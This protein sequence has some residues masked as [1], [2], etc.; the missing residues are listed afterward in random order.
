MTLEITGP[1]WIF[2]AAND[3]NGDVKF[4]YDIIDDGTTNG[5]DDFLTDNAEISLVVTSERRASGTGYWLGHHAW[6]E[7]SWSSK[8]KTW[9][10]QPLIRK[11]T[12]YRERFGAPIKVRAN[13]NALRTWAALMMRRSL[14]HTWVFTAA[15]EYDGDVK[16]IYTVEDGNNQWRWWFLNRYRRN[17]CCGNWSEWW[18]ASG[19]GY[20]LR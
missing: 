2:T 6:R 20:R 3:F 8:R 13:Y 7:A 14:A 12:R 10:R 5:V 17:Q 11:T 15:N 19:N 18:S 1:F 9:F 16:F 4:N